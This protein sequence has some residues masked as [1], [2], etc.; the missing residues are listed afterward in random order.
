MTNKLPAFAIAVALVGCSPESPRAR[1]EDGDRAASGE[2]RSTIS[3]NDEASRPVT[4]TRPAAA[5]DVLTLDGLGDLRIGEPVPA[6]SRWAERGAQASDTCRTIS[7]PDFPG[8]YAI[9]EDGKVRRIT[10]GQR[11]TIRLA[12]NIGVG[13]TEKEVL[14][15]FAGFRAEPHKYQATP[16]KYVTAPDAESGDPALRFEIGQDGRVS[17]IHVGIMPVLGYVEGCA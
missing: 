8:V 7:S 6:G 3:G 9:V 13:S 4:P 17:L 10:A 1:N 11:S 5:P 2:A 15:R 14:D 16:A 12:D